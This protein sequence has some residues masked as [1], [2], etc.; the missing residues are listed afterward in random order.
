M[1]PAVLP[2]AAYDLTG[3]K[4]LLVNPPWQLDAGNA[5]KSVASCYPSL[6][7]AMIAA[8]LEHCRAEV[9]IIDMQGIS[10][11]PALLQR[12]EPPDFVGLTATTV[13]AA[14]AYQLSHLIRRLW[15]DVRIVMGGVHPTIAP[16]EVLERSAAD[17]VIR[18]EGE[19]SM[20]ALVAGAPYEQIKGLAAVRAGAYWEHPELDWIADLNDM[21][22]PS[23]HLLP[24]DK[25]HA[26]LGGAL[27]QPSMSIIS[28]RG[29][30]GRCTFCNSAL[31][32]RLRFRS[33]ENVVREIQYLVE[34]HGIREIGFYDDTFVADR[35]RV[36]EICRLLLAH[37]INVTWTCM[38][39]VNFA[40]PLTL[41]RMAQAG[42]HMI[43]YGVE[44][45]DQ[46]ILKNIRKGIRLEDVRAVVRMTQRA[47]I[48]TR[49]SFMLG[50]PGE[51]LETMQK[52]LRFAL[53]VDPDLVQFN[54][55]TPYPGTQMYRWAD[56]QGYLLTKD[57]SQYDLST[58]VMRLPTV[59]PE[60]IMRFY[61]Y[62]NRRFYLRPKT[63]ARQLLAFLKHP[64]LLARSLRGTLGLLRTILTQS[65]ARAPAT[66]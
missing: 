38:S 55:T 27:R 39:R 16:R 47:G 45:A 57:W 17:C 9:Q 10:G 28:S 4:V 22:L 12:L 40:D 66:S 30:P 64:A 36:R 3:K 19:R 52:T 11:G 49:L 54:I 53:Q 42:C 60:Q 50:N 7:L 25:Y 31:H 58:V 32:R 2:S 65:R 24:L 6:G 18:G 33:A 44:S 43:C 46:E 59:S 48:T 5:W 41:E 29:C 63:I 14:E 1:S 23:Y 26:P 37:G 13:I 15:K 20:A 8:Y 56:E 62:A 21:P 34:N 51:T 61:R 35:Q